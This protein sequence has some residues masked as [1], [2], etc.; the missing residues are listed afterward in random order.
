MSKFLTARYMGDTD[1]FEQ[2]EIY[3]L[4]YKTND[5]GSIWVRNLLG[6]SQTYKTIHIFRAVWD[7]NFVPE[8]YRQQNPD[9]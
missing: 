2:G 1:K 3:R 9:L 7:M 6:Q 5:D 8:R 4:E